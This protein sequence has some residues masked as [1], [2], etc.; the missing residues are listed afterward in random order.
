[1]QDDDDGEERRFY[2]ALWK[3]VLVWG[4][5]CLVFEQEAEAL[6]SRECEASA[7]PAVL[8]NWNCHLSRVTLHTTATRM[9]IPTNGEENDV[10]RGLGDLCNYMR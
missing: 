10:N 3:V 9:W 1:M 6:V 4:A 7:P 2:H 8:R 5:E